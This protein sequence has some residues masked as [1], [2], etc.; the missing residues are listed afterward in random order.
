MKSS[1]R[2]AAWATASRAD[3]FS[4]ARIKLTALYIAIIAVVVLV[5]SSSFYAIHDLRVRDLGIRESEAG[6]SEAGTRTASRLIDEY[7]EI[8]QRSIVA[9]DLVTIA[10]AGALSY[11]LAGRTLRPIRDLLRSQRQFYANAAHDLRTPLAVM[12]T[13]TEV[14]LRDPKRIPG[15]PR[16]VLESSLEEIDRMS[17]MVEEMLLLSVLGPREGEGF[18][19]TPPRRGEGDLCD[20]AATALERMRP[21]AEA[22][23]VALVSSMGEPALLRLDSR[24]VERALANVLE[25]AVKYTPEGG[26]VSVALS[27]SRSHVDLVVADTGIGIPSADLPRIA[28]PFYRAD[29]ARAAD[30]GGAGLGLAI[31]KKILAEHG[32]SLEISSLEGQGTRVRLRFPRR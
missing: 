18:G 8:L 13:E 3:P 22:K 24:A 25:N 28:E 9:A 21:R 32:G 27:P 1:R 29:A 31:V 17:A 15:E 20:L 11:L 2:F 16:R 26:T 14:A 19:E 5:L 6:E 30:G 12:K 7:L 4:R 23:G 10:I